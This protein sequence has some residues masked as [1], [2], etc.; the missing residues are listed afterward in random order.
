SWT[1]PASGF[2]LQTNTDANPTTWVT[3][4]PVI[5]DALLGNRKRALITESVMS[6]PK[7]GFFRL[8]KSQ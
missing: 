8:I 5:P 4:D 6:D 2:V 3:P 1:T 7:S